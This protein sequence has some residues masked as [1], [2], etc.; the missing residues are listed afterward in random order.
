MSVETMPCIVIVGAG[1]GG[2]EL[3]T[4]LGNKLGKKQKARIILI[5]KAPTHFWKPLLHEVAA[6]TIDSNSDELNLFAHA[7]AHYF[8]FQLGDMQDLKRGEKE[9]LLAPIIDENQQEVVPARSVKYDYLV[10]A[11][12]SVSHDFNTPGVE[13]FCLSLDNRAQ[14]DKFQQYCLRKFMHAMY[15]AE[16]NDNLNIVIIGGG[17]TGVELAAELRRASQQAMSYGFNRF[18]LTRDVKIS[19]IEASPRILAALPERV[20]KLTAEKLNELGIV[21]YINERVTKVTQEGLYTLHEKF[22]PADIKIWVAGIKAP[23]FLKNLD[24]LET[25]K[26]NQL[27]VKQT[28]QTTLDENIFAFGDCASCPQPGLDKPVPPR[29]QAAH[30]QASLLAK[31]LIRY[32][33]G[34]TLLNYVYRDYGSLISLSHYDTVGNLMGKFNASFMLKG[35]LARFAYIMLYKEHLYKLHGFWSTLLMTLANN[36]TRK[37]KPRLKLH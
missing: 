20:S 36:L 37:L 3:A 26:I 25:N 21:V 1:A 11:V 29:A 12:G 28:L 16:N 17:A 18:D 7:Y 5:D 14:A 13:Q 27:L 19:L 9:L 2:L 23:D 31:S 34:K 8:E 35:K 22:Y 24:G 15:Q 32:I 10:I 30:Q 33:N 4:R 6:G